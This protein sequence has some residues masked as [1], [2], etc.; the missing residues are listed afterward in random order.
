[1]YAMCYHRTEKIATSCAAMKRRH[2]ARCG[3][4]GT[5]FK[6][7]PWSSESMPFAVYSNV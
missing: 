4:T 3:A 1:M 7:G 6:V 2:A 5:E